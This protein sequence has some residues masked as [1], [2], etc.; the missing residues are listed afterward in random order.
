MILLSTFVSYASRPRPS[1]MV[2]M[3]F[4]ETI[5]NRRP[6]TFA[7]SHSHG[8]NDKIDWISFTEA[9]NLVKGGKAAKPFVYLFHKTWC[10]ACKNLKSQFQDDSSPGLAD[11]I[12]L[13]KAFHMVN[14]EDDEAGEH[15]ANFRP[16]A[17]LRDSLTP[18]GPH[19]T[20]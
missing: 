12:E 17:C 11:V 16:G 18:H 19:A 20:L 7:R 2:T 5:A 10:G 1:G 3:Q 8:F 13:S 14:V 6:A 9:Q 4:L 15:E